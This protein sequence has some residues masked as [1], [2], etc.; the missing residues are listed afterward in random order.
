MFKYAFKFNAIVDSWSR[1][2]R[3]YVIEIETEPATRAAQQKAARALPAVI[4]STRLH[5]LEGG[6]RRNIQAMYFSSYG[7]NMCYNKNVC[8]LL[9]SL[10]F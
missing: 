1:V 4:D 9:K 2:D 5:L 8:D 10:L 7:L 3:I 6:A